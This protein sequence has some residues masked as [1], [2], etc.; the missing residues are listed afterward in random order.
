M[1]I[2]FN[3][4]TSVVNFVKMIYTHKYQLDC[5]KKYN[6]YWFKACK[7]FTFTR[8]VGFYFVNSHLVFSFFCSDGN[9]VSLVCE[10][11]HNVWTTV[12]KVLVCDEP[13]N[14]KDALDSDQLIDVKQ[15][16]HIPH[17][18]HD[19]ALLLLRLQQKLSIV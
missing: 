19:I 15:R 17:I 11:V 16:V 6:V 4:N 14:V 9:K 10:I 8:P 12:G 2:Y 1:F 7:Q 5:S 3:N 13:L 18:E